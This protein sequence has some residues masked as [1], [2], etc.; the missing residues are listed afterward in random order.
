M[1]LTAIFGLK[2]HDG[3]GQAVDLNEREDNPGARVNVLD[4]APNRDRPAA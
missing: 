4:S 2:V 3:A 1:W